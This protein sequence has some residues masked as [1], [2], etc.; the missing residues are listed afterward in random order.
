[1]LRSLV[2][3][4]EDVVF[5]S[6]SA[7]NTTDIGPTVTYS[8]PLTPYLNTVQIGYMNKDAWREIRRLRKINAHLERCL[9]EKNKHIAELEETI[10]E[11]AE[12]GLS[13][14]DSTGGELSLSK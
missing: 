1:M 7:D 11:L 6:I 9:F 8:A 14:P 13:I 4:P 12:A 3:K 2:T 5:T 10:K